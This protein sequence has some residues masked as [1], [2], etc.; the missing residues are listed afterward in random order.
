MQRVHCQATQHRVGWP[1]ARS[2]AFFFDLFPKRLSQAQ[3]H[4]T[5]FWSAVLSDW[6]ADAQLGRKAHLG[7]VS[8]LNTEGREGKARCAHRAPFACRISHGSCR[9]GCTAR[10][11]SPLPHTALAALRRQG[12][13]I[14]NLAAQTSRLV[15]VLIVR[16]DRSTQVFHGYSSVDS[17]SAYSPRF[18]LSLSL[19]RSRC[20]VCPRCRR[21]PS[22]ALG[23]KRHRHC[24]PTII[25]TSTKH[26]R[27]IPSNTRL[28]LATPI[29]TQVTT[30]I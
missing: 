30:Q 22:K 20:A 13:T 4:S 21:T 29:S 2:T 27:T 1:L 11:A 6:G 23:R 19:S 25:H 28:T 7:C 5:F 24:L 26:T 10:P 9:P 17:S 15:K 8:I 16:P 12:S 3:L 18:S 14:C